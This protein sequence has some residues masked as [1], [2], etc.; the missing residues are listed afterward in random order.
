MFNVL[1][2]FLD[3][4]AFLVLCAMGLSIIFGMMGIINLA[5]GEFMMLGAFIATF[6]AR[7]M[8]FPLAVIVGT[9]GVGIFGFLMD[10]LLIKRLYGRP[11]DSVVATWGL[12]LILQQ[13]MLI[14]FGAYIPGMTTPL[15]S[16]RVGDNAYSVY[17]LLLSGIAIVLLITV[18]IIF[19]KTRFGLDS[20]ATIQNPQNAVSMGINTPRIYSLT[21]MLGSALAGLSGALYAPTMTVAPTMGQ[22]FQSQ[23]MLTVIVGGAD[24]LIGTVMSGGTLGVVQGVLSSLYGSFYGR[25]GILFVTIVVIRVL[26]K[27][28]SGLVEKNA[29]KRRSG[30]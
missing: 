4:F 7:V 25:I 8:P 15:G 24:P 20:R 23:S 17:R 28:F 19:M 18:Y 12:S 30:K 14:L 16:F 5:H 10:R 2:Q 26:P 21:F 6:A 3:N 22:S 9:A 29:L 11:L 13:G 1:Y 27:G